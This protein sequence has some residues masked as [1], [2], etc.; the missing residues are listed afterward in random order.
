M[1]IF[2]SHS[3]ECD[4]L[5]AQSLYR[6][7]TSNEKKRAKLTC[8]G[9]APIERR[10]HH[11]TLEAVP[12]LVGSMAGLRSFCEKKLVLAVVENNSINP[13]IERDEKESVIFG[14]AFRITDGVC[15]EHVGRLL[16]WIC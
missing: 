10:L 15:T 3:L 4:I 11:S 13:N 9:A 14:C 16:S 6:I 5:I 12:S 1:C 2:A 7:G 8:I